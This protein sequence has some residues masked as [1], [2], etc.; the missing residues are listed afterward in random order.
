MGKTSSDLIDHNWTNTSPNAYSIVFNRLT[1]ALLTS[2]RVT[3]ALFK[4]LLKSV[5]QRVHSYNI[6]HIMYLVTV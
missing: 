5:K 4:K 1:L 6:I 3:S 2:E